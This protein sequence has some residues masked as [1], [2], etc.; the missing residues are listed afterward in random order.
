MPRSFEG[1]PAMLNLLLPCRCAGARRLP[2]ARA[3]TRRWHRCGA[4]VGPAAVAACHWSCLRRPASDCH[5]QLAAVLGAATAL[6][7][8]G[9]SAF[10][11]AG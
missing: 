11:V 7:V 8:L 1:E 6:F 3:R 5:F 4:G 9:D 10:A 2:A